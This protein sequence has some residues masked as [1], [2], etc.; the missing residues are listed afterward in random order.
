MSY[1]KIIFID[2]QILNIKCIVLCNDLNQN[3]M[4][5]LC[6]NMCRY[7]KSEQ[8]IKSEERGSHEY[9]W[10]TLFSNYLQ[11]GLFAVNKKG[12]IISVLNASNKCSS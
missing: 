10:S 1:Y 5:I 11:I 6:E 7:T 3:V 12:K 9:W 8:V 4:H 2:H